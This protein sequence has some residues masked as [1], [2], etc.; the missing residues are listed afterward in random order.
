M[1]WRLSIV[2][3]LLAGLAATAGQAAEIHKPNVWLFDM[4]RK[5]SPVWPGF[6]QV[7]PD[8]RYSAA[9][10]YG[11]LGE[12]KTMRAYVANN[13]DALAIDDVSGVGNRTGTFRVDVPNGEYA[14]W[15]LTGAMGNM[16]R[17][18]YLRAPHELLVQGR[19]GAKIEYP[20]A[21]LF[22]LAK[23]DWRPGDDVWAT[24]IRPRFRWV[25]VD[26]SASQGKIVLSFRRSLDFPVNA[27]VVAERGLASRVQN[28][29]EKIDDT[30]RQCFYGLWHERRPEPDPPAAVSVEERQ[31]GYI[32]AEAHCSEDVHPWS[33]PKPNASRG[34]IE[35]FATPGEQEQASFAVYARRDLEDV[36]FSLSELR[37]D[38]GVLPASAF[39][40]GLVHFMPWYAG[41]R[42]AT[43]YEMKECLIMRLRPTFIGKHTCKRFWITLNTPAGAASGAYRGRIRISARNAPPASLELAIRVVPVKLD[44]P[45]AERYMYF[46]T[47]YYLG[48]AYMPKFDEKRYWDAMRAEVR[49]MRDNQFCRAECI[50]PGGSSAVKIKDGR[51]VD[52]DLRDTARLMKII[53]EE[54][55]WPHDNT[56]I[57]RTG[58]LNILFGGHFRRSDKPGVEFVPDPEKRKLYAQAVKL[59]DE[60]A[61][62]EGWPEVAFECLG[63][64]TNY[65]ESGRKFA[66][67]LHT[68]LHNLGVANTLRGNGP[69]DMA[70]I[71][72]GLVKYPQP[73][74]AMMHPDELDIM[75][76]T[77]KRLWAYNFARSRY[78]M[79][80]FCWKH[81]ITRASYESGVYANGQPG[82]MFDIVTMFPMGLPTSMTTIEP[83]MWLK[84]LVQGAVDYEYLYTLDRRIK[85]GER[86]GKPEAVRAA[87][88]ARRWLDKKLAEI[89]YGVTYM[90]GDPRADRDVQG[91]FWPV[92]DLDRYRWQ[93][94]QFI[95]RIEHALGR[96][97]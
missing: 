77:G 26:A 17:L 81:G 80:W 35:F 37:G 82:N 14:V 76:R 92:R 43:V 96:R 1:N 12:P 66:I 53:R 79:G 18:R 22:R 86:S 15:V 47:M 54:H 59:I 71:E 30:R 3:V 68:L 36:T 42:D 90:R 21:A 39:Q 55:A 63:E 94:A 11:W 25:R 83:T 84:R 8:T 56:M 74:W 29:I 75:R 19:V 40:L 7:T 97:Q 57:C 61:K 41:R 6:A 24:F 16:W 87:R 51:V 62:T 13:L 95:M 52:V 73:N 9:R 20:E 93:A 34:R 69:C 45:P 64:F 32:V 46:G 88:E 31:R 44:T 60:R 78:A 5:D 67:E 38:A 28:E 48:R 2:L 4:G 58:A 70:A 27:V 33:E 85:Q 23:Y 65:G 89:P 72:R 49:F 91:K 10:G 50:I